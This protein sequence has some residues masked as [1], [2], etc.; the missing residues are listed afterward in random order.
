MPKTSNR[1][2]TI[3]PLNKVL[4]F[5]LKS[6]LIMKRMKIMLLSSLVVAAVAGAVAFKVNTRDVGLFCGTQTNSCP[7]EQTIDGFFFTNVNPINSWYCT[8]DETKT[9]T[10]LPVTFED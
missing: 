1:V 3:F 2:G 4:L 8:N 7:V 5:E 6:T 10:C 9:T